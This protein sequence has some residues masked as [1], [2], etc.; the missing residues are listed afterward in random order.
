MF[1]HQNI[2]Y[3][4]WTSA[5]GKTRNQ[6]DHILRDRRRHLSI[7]DVQSFRGAGCD[8]G[9]YLVN[10][11]WENIKENIK[12]SAKESLGVHEF[13]QHQPWFDEEYLDVLYQRKQAK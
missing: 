10:R 5:D 13:K 7:L 6:I 3:Y 9:N 4:N 1:P 11:A 8:T 12:N 2:H